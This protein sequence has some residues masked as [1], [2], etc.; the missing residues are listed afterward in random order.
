[1]LIDKEI[2]EKIPKLYKELG[3]KSQVA[4]ELGIS[5]STVYRYLKLSGGAPQTQ[6]TSAANSKIERV[7]VTPELIEK[8]NSLYSEYLNMSKVA[9]E[10]NIS[11]AVVKKYLNKENLELNK[12]Q[13]DDRDVL[14]FYIY[15]LFGEQSPEQPVSKWNIT[16]MQKFKAKGMPYR[17]QYLTLKYFYEI[18][19]GDKRKANGSIGM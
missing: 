11:S 13:Y 9:R 12:R 1:M 10:L 3:N 16:Q 7:K 19:K 5:V 4:K 15:R 14:F 6:A 2:I 8:I 17:G 18:K